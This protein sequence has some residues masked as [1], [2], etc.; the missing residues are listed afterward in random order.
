MSGLNASVSGESEDSD[1][2]QTLST[3]LENL[4]HAIENQGIRAGSIVAVVSDPNAP[5]DIVTANMV[6]NRPAYYYTLGRSEEHVRKNIKDVQNVSLE[7]THI[8]SVDSAN[9]VQTLR[10]VLENTEFPRAATV[11]ID[12]VNVLEEMAF[13]EFKQL[14]REL[15]SKVNEKDGVGILYGVKAQTDPSNRW[16]TMS[17]CDTVLQ[18]QH[19]QRGESVDEYL[20]VQKLSSG[21]E[22]VNNDTRKFQ[23]A[24]SLDIDITTSRNIS[25]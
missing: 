25:P 15:Q 3:G 24:R 12:P 18:V 22:L 11:I 9:P 7:T 4:D 20:T 5:G 16:F 13:E 21:Q 1:G 6:A 2:M 19:E 23:L 17:A 8:S 10:G 14:V